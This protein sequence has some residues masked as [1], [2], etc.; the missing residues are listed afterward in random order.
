MIRI[1]IES[2]FAGDRQTN[3]E[4]L[5][6]CVADC[7]AKKE[8][9]YASHAFFTQF[10]DDDRPDEREQGIEAGYAWAD[11]ADRIAFYV[12]YG[13]SRGMIGALQHYTEKGIDTYE[14]RY[15]G[16]NPVPKK[17][18]PTDLYTEETRIKKERCLR[19]GGCGT[20]TRGSEE[21]CRACKGV[22]FVAIE[23][24][25]IKTYKGVPFVNT[26]SEVD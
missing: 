5:E 26:N 9:P 2:P 10:L 24:P 7:L 11:K 15:I 19:C 22:G 23:V 14:F 17:P 4:Y 25:V 12:D 13:M 8:S 3:R 21:Y 18:E 16:K 6:R 1:V 20:E